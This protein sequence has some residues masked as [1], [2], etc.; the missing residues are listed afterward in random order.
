[1]YRLDCNIYQSY[2]ILSSIISYVLRTAY[3]MYSYH[4]SKYK[5]KKKEVNQKKENEQHT[6]RTQLLLLYYVPP[7]TE[8]VY[9]QKVAQYGYRAAACVSAPLSPLSSHSVVSSFF[10]SPVVHA[11]QQR[12]GLVGASNHLRPKRRVCIL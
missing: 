7:T 1:M 8:Y 2:H 5:T 4:T 12:G 9:M 10:C 6:V 3:S 11:P